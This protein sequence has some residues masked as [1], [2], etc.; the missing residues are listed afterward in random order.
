[1]KKVLVFVCIIGISLVS[2]RSSKKATTSPYVPVTTTPTTTQSNTPTK[3]FTVPQQQTQPKQTTAAADSKYISTRKEA[4]TFTQPADQNQNSYFI[5]TG[6]FSSMENAKK[7]QQTLTGEGFTPII[8]QSETG[9][10]RVSVDSYSTEAPARVRLLQIRQDFPQYADT[11]LLI[12][13]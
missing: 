10:Y 5:I 11:W 7:F 12:K 6:S 8:L 1:M 4:V 3:V 9:F 2:C 13:Q